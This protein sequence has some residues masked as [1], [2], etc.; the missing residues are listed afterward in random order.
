MNTTLHM[1]NISNNKGAMS[2]SQA[3]D[4][5]GVSSRYL[6]SLKDEGIVPF[7]SVGSRILFRKETLDAFLKEKEI[8]VS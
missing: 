5:I 2:L 3:A 4:Y 8:K 1:Q 7:V 6:W